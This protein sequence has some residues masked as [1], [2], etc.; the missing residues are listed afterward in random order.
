VLREDPNSGRRV[1]FPSSKPIG[2]T[3]EDLCSAPEKNLIAVVVV[4]LGFKISQ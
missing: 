3:L 1:C 2:G 4:A